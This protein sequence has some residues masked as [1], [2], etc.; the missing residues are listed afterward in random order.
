[1]ADIRLQANQDLTNGAAKA[2]NH[3]DGPASD[4]VVEGGAQTTVELI[5]TGEYSG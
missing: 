3:S 1:V 2:G 4:H 5:T